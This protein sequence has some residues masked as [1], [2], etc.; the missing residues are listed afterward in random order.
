[1]QILNTLY[2]YID[3][4]IILKIL[5]PINKNKLLNTA[6]KI[7]FCKTLPRSLKQQPLMTTQISRP[8]LQII[9]TKHHSCYPPYH[10]L[11]ITNSFNFSALK[12]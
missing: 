4:N 10:F 5:H 2:T 9:N 6:Q 1:M 7:K 11:N 3:I 12:M 8:T